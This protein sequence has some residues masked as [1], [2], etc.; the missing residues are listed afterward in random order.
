MRVHVLSLSPFWKGGGSALKPP[1]TKTEARPSSWS[2]SLLVPSAHVGVLILFST[3][4]ALG[5]SPTACRTTE[6]RSPLVLNDAPERGCTRRQPTPLPGF[7]C[8]LYVFELGPSPALAPCLACLPGDP[9]VLV[10]LWHH[11]EN[12]MFHCYDSS[13]RA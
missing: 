12:P 5:G 9:R 7:C 10:P 4:E 11:Q 13:P 8:A 6:P 2:P 3:D 1:P